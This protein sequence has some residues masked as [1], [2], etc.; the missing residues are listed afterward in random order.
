MRACTYMSYTRFNL[1]LFWL[2]SRV[3]PYVGSIFPVI[4]PNFYSIT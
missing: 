2:T 1:F 3:G 4:T